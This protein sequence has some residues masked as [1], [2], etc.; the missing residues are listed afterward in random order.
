MGLESKKSSIIGTITGGRIRKR[1]GLLGLFS[2]SKDDFS[3]LPPNQRKKKLQSKIEEITG[4]ICQETAARDGL[5][6]MKQVYESN[7]ALGDPMSIQGQLTENGHRLDKLRSEL[8]KFQDFLDELEGK[9]GA[10][11]PSIRTKDISN[12][13]GK[14]SVRKKRTS[15]TKRRSSVSDGG[16]SL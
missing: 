14:G 11:S 8:K 6:K 7:P 4:K 12:T 1:S 2:N 16:E 9:A 5:M 13:D 15:R 10:S 3:E